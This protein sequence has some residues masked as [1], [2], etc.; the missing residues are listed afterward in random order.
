MTGTSIVPL[1]LAGSVAIFF[2][3]LAVVGIFVVV[4][5]ANRADPDPAGRRP[6]AVYYFGVSFFSVF[7]IL[8]GSFGFVQSMVQL[9]GD[10]AG[11]NGSAIH[12]IGDAVARS[13]VMSSIVTLAGVALLSIH[14]PRGLALSEGADSRRGPA[15]RVAQSYVVGVAFVSV[16]IAAVATIALVYQLIRIL[17]PG[18]FLLSGSRTSATRPVIAALFLAVAAS[19][20]AVVHLRLLP[21]DV[22]MIGRFP[23]HR[24]ATP[25]GPG[26]PAGPGPGGPAGPGPGG[27]AAPGPGPGV[28]RQPVAPPGPVS[29][30]PPPPPSWPPP[31]G[32]PPARPTG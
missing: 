7:A 13:A 23:A 20:L 30:S 32:P 2:G 16:L 15:G 24:G 25:P 19:V 3:I 17:G 27:P 9:I 1:A 26:G 28:A 6:L 18:V 22:R 5:V 10:H 14:L 8:L 29:G 21:P 12:P 31:S 11:F 4:V